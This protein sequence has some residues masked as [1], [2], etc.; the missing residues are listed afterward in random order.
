ME[1]KNSIRNHISYIKAA[2]KMAL[3]AKK[4]GS[5]AAYRKFMRVVRMYEQELLFFRELQER[6]KQ[7]RIVQCR[8]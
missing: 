2:R 1:L 8:Q 4:R 6:R 3:C 7:P 5:D